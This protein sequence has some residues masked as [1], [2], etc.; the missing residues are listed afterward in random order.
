MFPW[1]I[2]LAAVIS[3]VAFWLSTSIHII[4]YVLY[5]MLAHRQVKHF[6]D[7]GEVR[8]GFMMKVG[9]YARNKLSCFISFIFASFWSLYY[10]GSLEMV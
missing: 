8:R 6:K 7:Y 9:K 5:Y 1:R 4:E 2:L 10:L 3:F